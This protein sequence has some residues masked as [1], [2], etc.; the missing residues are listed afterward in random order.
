M[1]FEVAAEM[2]RDRFRARLL[3]YTRK[4]Y[5]LLPA[6]EHPNILDIGCGSGV[7]TMELARLSNG[8]VIGVDIDK[9]AIEKLRRKIEGAGMRDRVKAVD[10]SMCDIEFA[11]GIFDI[12]W[13]EGAIH[14]VGFSEGLRRWRNLIKPGGFFA[15]HDRIAGMQEN[16]RSISACG[17]TL[18]NRFIVPK[19]AWWDDYYRP[20]ENMI[21]GLRPKYQNDATALA[22]L[23]KE[24]AEVEDFKNNPAHHGSV[25]Y[26]MQKKENAIL[27]AQGS[28]PQ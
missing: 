14:V 23:D 9:A 11:D 1:K 4:A 20:L 18:I 15:V 24:Q 28:M 8:R 25:F 6:L 27:H 10:C 13:T 21:E 7:V 3:Q 22:F 5:G 17:Y 16:E 19:E 12:I 2:D 26:V